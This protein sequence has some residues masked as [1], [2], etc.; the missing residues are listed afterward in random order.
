LNRWLAGILAVVVGIPLFFAIVGMLYQLLSTM[1]D[2]RLYPVPGQL[3]DI[4]GRRLHLLCV[5]EGSPT[6][7][8]EAALDGS[9]VNWG[10]IQPRVATVAKTC[11]YDRAGAGWSDSGPSP[12]DA[13]AIAA[14]LKAM[15]D[16]AHIP[17]PYVLVGH[18]LGGLD[19]RAFAHDYPDRVAGIVLVEATHPDLW[20]QL[21][22]ALATMPSDSELTLLPWL[23]RVGL[24]RL[25]WIDPFPPSPDLPPQHRVAARA[26]AA[27]TKTM[28]AISAELRALPAS[29][30]EVRDA[31]DL[32]DVPL[33]V[34]TAE[35]TYPELPDDLSFAAERA[36]RMLQEDLCGLSRDCTHRLIAGA[37]HETIVY[38]RPY[39]GATAVA[40]IDFVERVKMRQASAQSLPCAPREPRSVPT[41]AR[42][43]DNA[44]RVS[45]V[46]LIH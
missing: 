46:A 14:D 5:G 22:A 4:G 19:V 6:V 21:P 25:G 12:R 33:L 45:A 28:T 29:L 36:W 7:V 44:D 31:G 20:R 10:W 27:S 38:K 34:L 9:A 26:L 32:G 23:S 18:S 8:L 40:I 37:D 2:E 11:A 42:L 13:R 15:L 24:A 39:S 43:T 1:R 17:G 41:T 16:A 3:V 35:N 30:D